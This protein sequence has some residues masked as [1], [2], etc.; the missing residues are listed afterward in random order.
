[1]P[2]GDEH[3]QEEDAKS[4]TLTYLNH[5]TLTL[6]TETILLSC[7]TS[8]STTCAGGHSMDEHVAFFAPGQSL[9]MR[10]IPSLAREL[11]SRTLFF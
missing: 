11:L 3:L 2:R 8:T 6:L 10:Q 7:L 5:T 4:G 1:M 9:L